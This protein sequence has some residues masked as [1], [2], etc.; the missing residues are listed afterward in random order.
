[1]IGLLH[2]ARVP[3]PLRVQQGLHSI[4]GDL[5]RISQHPFLFLI[6]MKNYIFRKADLN[7]FIE[8][9]MNKN[10]EKQKKLKFYL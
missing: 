3:D 5:S 9:F 1:M 10:N 2:R 8:I 6:L 7:K 4:R